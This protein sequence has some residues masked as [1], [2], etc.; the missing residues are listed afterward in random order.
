MRFL[1]F[2]S[3]IIGM[4]A[5]AIAQSGL[6]SSGGALPDLY[7]SRRAAAAAMAQQISAALAG[8]KDVTDATRILVTS[9][10]ESLNA[11]DLRIIEEIATNLRRDWPKAEFA[12]SLPAQRSPTAADG[13]VIS[14]NVTQEAGI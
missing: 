4:L 7:P 13:L 9:A 8:D 5:P 14:V 1:L 2:I 10:A 6:P 3:A 11:D 12:R